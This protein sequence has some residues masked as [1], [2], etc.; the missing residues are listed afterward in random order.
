MY[1]RFVALATLLTVIPAPAAEPPVAYDWRTRDYSNG[2][3]ILGCGIGFTATRADGYVTVD[4]SVMARDGRPKHETQLR[5][6][7]GRRQGT[8]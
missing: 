6:A 4:L 5:V 8:D 1:V 2:D 7:A 3:R